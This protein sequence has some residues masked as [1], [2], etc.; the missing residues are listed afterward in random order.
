MVWPGSVVVLI[1]S[2]LSPHSLH[3]TL[4][5]LHGRGRHQLQTEGPEGVEGED[6][7]PDRGDA[8]LPVGLCPRLWPVLVTLDLQLIII[9]R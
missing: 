1:H 5:L 7:L 6:V 9:S 2:L 3:P 4:L 8:E